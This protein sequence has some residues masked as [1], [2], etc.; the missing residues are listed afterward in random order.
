MGLT[1]FSGIDAEV[2]YIN[3]VQVV[4]TTLNGVTTTAAVLNYLDGATQTAH[5]V[6]APVDYADDGTAKDL[7]TDARR[8]AAM[9]ATNAKLNALI[10][11]LEDFGIV[12]KV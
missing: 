5:I 6:A 8:V 7:D 9:N 1:H 3:G 11:A 2:L 10:V 12:L 4:D